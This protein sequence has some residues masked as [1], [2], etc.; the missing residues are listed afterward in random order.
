MTQTYTQVFGGTNIYPSDVSYLAFDLSTF[1]VILAWPTETNAPNALATYVAARIMNVNCIGSSRKVFLPDATQASVGECSLFNNTGTITF[2]I[3]NNAGSVVCNV[4]PGT[5]WQV[6]MTSNSTPGGM[7]SSYQFGSTVSQANAGALAGAGLKAIANTLNQAIQITSLSTNYTL[8]VNDRATLINWTGSTG[9]INLTAAA[10]LGSDW[11]C[12]IR[13]SG[14]SSI[15]LDPNGTELINNALTLTMTIGQSLMIICDGSNFYT[16]AN[17]GGSAAAF[18]YTSINVGGTGDYTL[19]GAQLN[20]I[21]Y[22]LTGVLTGNRNIIVPATVQQYWITNSTTG[23]F[24]LTVKTSAGTGIAVAANQAEILYCDGTNV[25]VG[26]TPTTISYP[27]SIA[28][29]GTGA[30][31]ASAARASLGSTSVGDAV[32]TATSAANAQIAIG[33]GTV[34]AQVFVATT[35]L[36]AQ[37]AIGSPS[38]A[39]SV[40][41]GIGIL[42]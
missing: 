15:T 21:S 22:N 39:F 42:S 10:T 1:D 28:N 24:T 41:M 31:S 9:T 20:R 16:V 5:L 2:S 33:A 6:Y 32:F 29:G 12:Y 18:D 13:N 38:K 25:V 8:G 4:A 40:A 23:S 14:T 19:T 11:F 37:T 36:A 17:G 30:T 27:V 7:W 34:G 26:Q 35:Q 3:V